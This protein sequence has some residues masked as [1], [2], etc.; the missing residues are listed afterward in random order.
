VGGMP[1]VMARDG[2]CTHAGLVR[3]RTLTKVVDHDYTYASEVLELS[4]QVK[5]MGL[6]TRISTD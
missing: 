2:R 6:I 5:I 3:R 4:W 1:M